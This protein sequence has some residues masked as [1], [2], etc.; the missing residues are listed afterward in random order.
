MIES[1]KKLSSFV[2]AGAPVLPDIDPQASTS[3]RF[4]ESESQT[5]QLQHTSTST[6]NPPK[7]KSMSKKL[8]TPEE[9]ESRK[10]RRRWCKR[11]Q[12][13]FLQLDVDGKGYVTERDLHRLWKEKGCDMDDASVRNCPACVPLRIQLIFFHRSQVKREVQRKF[14][15]VS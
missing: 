11:I 5:T 15:D 8:R 3:K 2:A 12:K 7:K 14:Y 13:E 10:I 6:P 4:E 1:F 9:D